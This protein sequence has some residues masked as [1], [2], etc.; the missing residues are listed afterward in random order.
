MSAKRFFAPVLISLVFISFFMGCVKN[1]PPSTNV[2]ISK[3]KSQITTSS[4]GV[5]DTVI[6]TYDSLGR[7]ITSQTDTLVMAYA[8]TANT[9]TMTDMLNG[10]HFLTI[11]NTNSAG[12]ATS[13][14]KGFVY[15]FNAAGYLTNYSYTGT[16]NY[17]STIYAI[18]GGD[19]DISV[20]HQADS[21][22]NNLVTTSYTYLSTEDSRD[23]GLTFLGKQSTNLINTETITQLTNSNSY[24]INYTYSYTFDSKGRVSQQVQSS[25][26]ATYTTSYTYY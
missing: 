14:S 11:Y 25:G 8:Y 15:A 3:V 16:G 17:D 2:T 12:Q 13:D 19:I 22:T 9:V 26:T 6:Y 21:A 10:V 20:Q 23:F 7:Q 1:P 5:P 4:T 24:S 18:S